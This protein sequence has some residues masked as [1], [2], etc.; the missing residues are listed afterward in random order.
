[1]SCCANLAVRPPARRPLDVNSATLNPDGVRAVNDILAPEFEVL[2]FA[3]RYAALPSGKGRGGHPVAE[4]KGTLGKRLL[5]IGPPD[6]V[7]ARH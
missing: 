5:L 3:V 4:R 7:F 6:T 1:M 2:G